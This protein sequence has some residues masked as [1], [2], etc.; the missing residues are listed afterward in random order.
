[1]DG[2]SRRNS[3]G[4]RVKARRRT[5]G[6]AVGK[7]ERK[8]GC[9]VR[10]VFF[11]VA[12]FRL[13]KALTFPLTAITGCPLAVP[14][15]DDKARLSRARFERPLGE[16]RHAWVREGDIEFCFCVF[17]FGLENRNPK[18]LK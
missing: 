2:V 14:R 9:R 12:A 3:N 11:G 17:L 10:G 7:R 1:V 5:V 18:T 16:V 15:A 4:T 6:V 13:A 8:S